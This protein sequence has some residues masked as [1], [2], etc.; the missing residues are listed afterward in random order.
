PDKPAVKI[1]DNSQILASVENAKTAELRARA[2]ETINKSLI[3]QAPK[4]GKI[5]K[6]GKNELLGT[7]EWTLSNGVK[8]IIKPTKFKQ[9]EILMAAYSDGGLSKVA[10]VADLPSGMLAAGIV[11][12]NGLAGF[13]QT[14]LNKILTGKIAN[15][16]PF[17]SSYEEGFNGNSSVSDFETMLQLVYLYFTA[18]RKDDNAYAALMNNYRAGLANSDSDPRKAFSDSV[19]VM[20]TNHNARNVLINLK[21]LDKIDQEKALGIFRERF[22]VPADFTFVFTGN[23][24]PEND[25]I[26]KAVSTYLGGLKSKK[27]VEKYTD[28]NIRKPL[29]KTNN[30]FGREMKVKKASNFIV[31]SASLPYN[32]TNR[33]LVTAIGSILNIRYLE[34]IRE[35]EGGS[36]GVGVRGGVNNIPVDEATLM[37]QFD[38]DPQKQ[39]KLMEIIHSEIAEIVSNGPRAD[40]VQKVKE[41]MLKKYAEDLNENGWWSNAVQRY[42][43]DKLNLVTDYKPSVEAMTAGSIRLTLKDIVNQGNTIEVVMKPE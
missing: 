11:A 5:A 8:I 26:K 16:S 14:E 35:K 39:A 9:D 34:T 28:N 38:T 24:N 42:Y 20:L 41:N 13:S 19:G 29:G 10:D 32:M 15:V 1:P 4:P 17:I 3:Q 36:Y 25:S 22:A 40:D 31:Y 43:R 2:E 37:M 18:P 12:N 30:Y 23:I 21:T 33:T 27:L 7:T 6:T